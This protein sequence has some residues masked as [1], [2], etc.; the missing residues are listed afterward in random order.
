M[1]N[2]NINDIREILSRVCYYA[3]RFASIKAEKNFTE[4]ELLFIPIEDEDKDIAEKVEKNFKQLV[5]CQENFSRVDIL[6]FKFK[7]VYEPIFQAID[8]DMSQEFIDK[9]F[10]AG[11]RFVIK[12]SNYVFYVNNALYLHTFNELF[13]YTSDTIAEEIDELPKK[14]RGPRL[15]LYLK[16][17]K[18]L[19]LNGVEARFKGDKEDEYN[20]L[21]FNLVVNDLKTS[22]NADINRIHPK[23]LQEMCKALGTTEQ[24][25]IT[26]KKDLESKAL[27]PKPKK[28]RRN[29]L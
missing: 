3:K 16:R 28:H 26:L 2:D 4:N 10:D 22:D 19:I 21:T 20:R 15:T 24:S 9:C 23:I 1:E 11:K 17:I 27:S 5:D 8:R 13:A 6:N 29:Y 14:E 12:A 25:L 18:G 7:C